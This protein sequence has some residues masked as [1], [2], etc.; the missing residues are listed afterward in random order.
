MALKQIVLRKRLE[1]LTAQMN[2]AEETRAELEARR[3]AMQLREEELE[4]AVGEVTEE[5]G[6]EEKTAL[7][8]ETAKWEQDEEALAKA[9]EENAETTRKLQEQIDE[10][11]AELN[12]LEQR[13]KKAAE[14][15]AAANEERK[16]EKTMNTR[17]FFGM[18]TQERDAFFA[19]TEVKDFIA[20]TR[21]MIKEKRA[22]NGADLTIP[23]VILD[24][25]RE[26]VGE[27]SKLLKHVNVQRINGKGRVNVMGVVPEAIWTEMCAKL[28]EI[29]LSFGAV[30]LDGYK[31]GA[32]VAVC[33]AVL[34]D[35]EVE[36]ATKV[37]EALGKAMGRALDKAIL[38]GTGV[39]MPT[40]ILTALEAGEHKSTNIVSIS[41]KTGTA[42]FK[43]IITAAGEAANDY[44]AGSMFWAMNAKT[45][46][47]LVAEAVTFNAAGAVVSGQ[48]GEMP[49]IG[50]KIELVSD[51]PDNVIIGGYG[52][53]YAMVERAE[54][55]FATSEEVRFI[56]DQTVFKGTARYDGKPAVEKAFV[57]IS[58]TADKPTAVGV[59]FAPDAAN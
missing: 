6:E 37:I 40:G 29:D 10:L 33:N 44:S 27:Y 58:L 35:N 55:K 28:N 38:F 9:E 20:N 53:L 16:V 45:K 47:T 42:L 46:S 19:L 11:Q 7:D 48:N 4:K 25:I 1:G 22:V 31:V 17:K 52:E 12:E 18:N 34:E 13:S 54:M 41:G 5:T 51:I 36:L 39:K 8:E 49:V 50:G 43:A 2:G 23:T 21:S 14:H 15:K 57:A 56:D 32:F 59:T 26:R 30:E 24:L 3:A